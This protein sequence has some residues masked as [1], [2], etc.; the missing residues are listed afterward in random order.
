MKRRLDRSHTHTTTF[1]KILTA[2]IYFTMGA[3]IHYH[4]WPVG[5]VLM[6]LGGVSLLVFT[7]EMIAE[8]A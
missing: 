7:I 6:V 3:G 1:G 8:E 4:D 5:V 2:A